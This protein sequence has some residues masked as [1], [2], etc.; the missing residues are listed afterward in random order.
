MPSVHGAP[1]AHAILEQIQEGVVTLDGTW[2]YV[3]VNR[4]AAELL[5]AEPDALL[6]E[7]IWAAFP[8]VEAEPFGPAIRRSKSRRE[9]THAEGYYAPLGRWSTS[10]STRPTAG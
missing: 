8:E 1:E 9:P 2:R 6:G 10:R 7:V 5:G 3:Y 4:R